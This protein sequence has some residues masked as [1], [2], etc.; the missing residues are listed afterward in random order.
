L[1]VVLFEGSVVLGAAEV[2]VELD[3]D[4]INLASRKDGINHA[5]LVLALDGALG[6]SRKIVALRRVLLEQLAERSDHVAV[7]G[8]RLATLNIEV[9]TINNEVAKGTRTSV[10]GFNRTE[11]FPELL[12]H[13]L[14]LDGA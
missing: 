4:V 14:G 5:V 2:V 3:K 1:A 13:L 10:G 7:I 8:R 9:K 6:S 11:D 12:S